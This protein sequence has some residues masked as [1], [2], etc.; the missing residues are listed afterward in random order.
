[1]KG[2][3]KLLIV[4]TDGYPNSAYDSNLNAEQM[5]RKE[6]NRARANGIGTLGMMVGGE[7]G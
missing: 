6:I 5:V 3:K 4:I 7:G 1:M 2:K